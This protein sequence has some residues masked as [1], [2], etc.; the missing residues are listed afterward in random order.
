MRGIP[1]SPFSNAFS[2]RDLVEM[3]HDKSESELFKER[4]LKFLD[5][6]L[7]KLENYES[8]ELIV[9][10]TRIGLPFLMHGVQIKPEQ[11]VGKETSDA[12]LRMSS[13][14]SC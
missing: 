4:A 3:T 6:G 14:L 9:D 10:D 1:Q 11:R 2:E 8:N 5:Q 7:I 12:L 13:I